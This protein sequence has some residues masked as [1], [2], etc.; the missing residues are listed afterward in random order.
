MAEPRRDAL[1]SLIVDGYLEQLGG[2]TGDLHWTWSIVE[3]LVRGRPDIAW[4]ML[5]EMIR[6]CP[7]DA[8][9]G[10]LA[11]GPLEDYLAAHGRAV[12]DSV[13]AEA[14]RNPQLRQALGGTW[15]N[16][17]TDD[18]WARIVATRDDGPE[19][20]A[21]GEEPEGWIRS[22]FEVRLDG[23]PPMHPGSTD[24]AEVAARARLRAEALAAKPDGA[25][26]WATPVSV[27]VDLETG[28]DPLPSPAI[29]VL[30]AIIEALAGDRGV[31]IDRSLV[32]FAKV[33]E[34]RSPEPGVTVSVTRM[35]AAQVE[36][37]DDIRPMEEQLDDPDIR[38]IAEEL[39]LDWPP[40]A[41][42]G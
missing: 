14:A 22:T 37:L 16:A 41:A 13:E 36:A 33:T 32:R 29:D 7:D 9:L 8:A 18:V 23:L 20:P 24:P 26:P 12:I 42:P 1:A 27:D 11:A 40:P 6:R 28:L 31:F 3:E 15:Q 10:L 21:E 39:G 30:A 25:E 19:V 4:P 17:M 2:W 34:L 35:P 38:A 5:L